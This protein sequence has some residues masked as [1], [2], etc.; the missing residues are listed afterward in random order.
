MITISGDG[1]NQK[2]HRLPELQEVRL[3]LRIRIPGESLSGGP[4]WMRF[5]W[6]T[7]PGYVNIAMEN[8]HL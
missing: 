1:K 8:G 7:R 6:H 4:E 2:T 3:V 5:L